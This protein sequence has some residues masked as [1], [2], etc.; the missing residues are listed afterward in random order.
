MDPRECLIVL[1]D[2]D[3]TVGAN[4]ADEIRVFIDFNDIYDAWLPNLN[5]GWVSA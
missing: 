2:Y 1:K 4:F 5:I 3:R